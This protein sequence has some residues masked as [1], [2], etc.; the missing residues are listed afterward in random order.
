MVK[1]NAT[2]EE[3]ASARDLVNRWQACHAYPL[4]TFQAT[5]RTKLSRNYPKSAIVAQRLTRMPTI[6]DKPK[7]YPA[8][9]LTTMQDIAG[10]RAILDTVEDVDRLVNEYK[11]L[12]RL[13]HDLVD[14][15]DYISSPRSEDGYRS[16][17]IQKQESSESA[18]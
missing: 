9:Q 17:S 15:K 1:R 8:M 18:L 10:V 13:E 3:I 7:R 5:L 2:P 12:T 14:E 6:I 4:N 11:N 16:Y